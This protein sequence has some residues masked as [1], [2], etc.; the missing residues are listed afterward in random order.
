M[1][2]A[3]ARIAIGWGINVIDIPCNDSM[4]IAELAQ[5]LQTLIPGAEV[6]LLWNNWAEF[7]RWHDSFH[8][9]L[10]VPTMVRT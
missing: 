9:V 4:G 2:T 6:N 1:Q 10:L 7:W 8:A 3:E 5:K